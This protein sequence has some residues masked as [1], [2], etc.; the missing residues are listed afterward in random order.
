L[1]IFSKLSQAITAS[2]T[3]FLIVLLFI[4]IAVC[5]YRNFM[6]DDTFIHIGYAKDISE[7]KGYSFAGNKTYGSTSPI[8]PPLIASIALARIDFENSA[9]F[10]SFLF[11]IAGILL[12]YITARLRFSNV[13]SLCAAF[14]FS[15]NTYFLRWSL[16]G[17]ESTASCFFIL[18]LV[19]I[20]FKERKEKV[21]RF[22]YFIAGLSPL[23]RPEFYLFVPI[24]FFFLL[25][26]YST[27]EIYLKLILIII[28]SLLWNCFAYIYFGTIT[29]S[30]FLIKAGNTFFST[31]WDTVVRSTALLLSGNLIELC[32]ILISSVL[33]FINYKR[34]LKNIVPHL[35]K[36]EIALFIIWISL[37]YTYYTLK[38]VTIL[39]RYSLV[40]L[41]VVILLTVF[42]LT[43][44]VEQ[45]NFTQK[46]KNLLLVGLIT[47]SLLFHGL[48]TYFIVKPDA[49]N[50]VCGFQREYK[51]IAAIIAEEGH[52]ESSVALSDVGIIGVY[53][54]SKIY[55]FVGLVDKDRFQFSSKHDYF[56]N[57]KPRYLILR[58]EIKLEELKDTSVVFQEIYATHIP[59]LGINQRRSIKVTAYKVFWN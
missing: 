36:S 38:N 45:F 9:R 2:K 56:F 33:L 59:G 35:I 5:L 24:L 55:D 58:E 32:F 16:T 34:K 3:V 22:L 48:F 12:M 15:F 57:K 52:K 19:Y 26:M 4:I 29:P 50:F 25:L 17:M 31:D 44:V 53:S 30:T 47:A 1:R 18:I 11:S 8:W 20:L 21:S 39:S 7:G 46:A 14:L 6:P 49:D 37:F 28:P 43:K 27:Q 13:I 23:I 10:L 54:G 40:L 42:L 51:K 41:P